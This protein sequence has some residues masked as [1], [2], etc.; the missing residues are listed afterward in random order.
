M[1]G[2]VLYSDEGETRNILVM[3]SYH[4]GL[5]W[6]DDI[7]QAIEDVFENDGGH[8]EIFF[9][10]LDT[11]R[12]AGELYFQRLSEFEREKTQLAELDFALIIASDNNALRFLVDYGEELFGP[13][14]IV[15]C[16]V[17]DFSMD[18]LKERENI[19][20]IP[21]YIDYQSTL[22]MMGRLHPERNKL[23]I[24]VDRSISGNAVAEE[25]KKVEGEFRDRFSFEYLRDFSVDS[26]D[27]RISGLSEES[28]IY[29]LVMNIDKEGIFLSYSDAIRLVR[30]HSQVPIYGSWDF[31]FG[32]GVLGGIMVSGYS[33][34][35]QAAN[36][37]LRIL[38]GEDPA[39]IPVT[40]R[41]INKTMFD[42]REMKIYGIKESQ[43]P[44]NSLV[45]YKP[46]PF[47]VKYRTTIIIIVSLTL[48][49][50]L[51]FLVYNQIENRKKKRLKE[52]N[53]ILD[54]KVK[55]ALSEVKTL[56]GLLPICAHCKKVRDD[57]GYWNQI[58]TYVA[59]HTE[60]DFSHGLCPDCAAEIYPK[61]FKKEK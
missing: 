32:K 51:L 34:G 58:E 41:G 55:E 9:E 56:S 26:I 45:L 3:H 61:H 19:T 35:E 1:A 20:G 21:E 16:G 13:V 28:L 31:F 38:K 25:L 5:E 27:R 12:N 40:F 57:S 42:Y 43:L 22:H 46:D 60:A 39:R 6:T 11:K 37:A 18:M 36:L 54:E 10:Y 29:L 24:I 48:G 30:Q 33:Q 2:Y 23:L 7:S 4:Q 14:P 53:R 49:F 15:F 59:K 8:Y 52:M 47:L 50:L 44:E 17:N